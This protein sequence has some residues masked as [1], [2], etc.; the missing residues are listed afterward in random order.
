MFNFRLRVQLLTCFGF[1]GVHTGH[2]RF[3]SF[4]F[5]A[6]Y[7]NCLDNVHAIKSLQLQSKLL[8]FN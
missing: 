4:H 7:H 6:L 2:D 3:L 8:F 5:T 1:I